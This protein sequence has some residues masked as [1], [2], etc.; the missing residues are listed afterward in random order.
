V[1]PRGAFFAEICRDRTYLVAC[2]IPKLSTLFENMSCPMLQ[3]L[4]TNFSE[5]QM[6]KR[7]IKDTSD[8]NAI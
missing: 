2:C 5:Y 1:V 8:H 4:F 3:M 6:V 7:K